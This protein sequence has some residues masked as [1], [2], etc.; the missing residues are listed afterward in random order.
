MGKE[1]FF[2]YR[3]L[4]KCLIP[5]EKISPLVFLSARTETQFPPCL[6]LYLLL[7]LVP[8]GECSLQI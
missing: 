4:G 6:F 5:D 1:L 7:W 2:G 8:P 3:P